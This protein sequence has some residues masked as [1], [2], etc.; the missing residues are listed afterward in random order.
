MQAMQLGSSLE[1]AV[2]AKILLRGQVAALRGQ[3]ELAL[4]MFKEVE[5]A[6]TTDKIQMSNLVLESNFERASL[7]L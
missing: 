7:L 4:A 2:L 1:A 5:Q 3:T 6:V